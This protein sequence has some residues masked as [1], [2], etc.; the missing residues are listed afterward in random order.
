MFFVTSWFSNQGINQDVKERLP[1]V[2]LALPRDAAGG[3]YT[4]V[5]DNQ[6]KS[7]QMIKRS[8]TQG[9]G[10]VG[11]ATIFEKMCA[12]LGFVEAQGGI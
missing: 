1:R 4:M 3:L 8:A 11:V 9:V 2:E 10:A 6:I 7:G 5:F 12:I